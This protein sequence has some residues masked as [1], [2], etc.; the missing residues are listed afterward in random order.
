VPIWK[1]AY[2]RSDGFHPLRTEWPSYRE[3]VMQWVSELRQSV[4]YLQTRDDV[5]KEKIAYQGISNGAVWA[6]IFLALEPRLKVAILPLGGLLPT[7]LHETPMPPEIDGLHYAPRVTQP[8]LML[9]GRSDAIFPYENAQ[10]PLF[11][12]LGTPPQNK[13]HKTY[14]G[15]HSS[16]GWQNELIKESLNWLD[17]WFG[18]VLR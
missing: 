12:M 18:P 2:E 5:A 17:R 9:N 11:R 15:G 6:P 16:F 7:S 13:E 14:P 3:H 4:D 10:V 8:V 1:G